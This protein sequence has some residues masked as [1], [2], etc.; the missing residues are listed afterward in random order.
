M[1]REAFFKDARRIMERLLGDPALFPDDA[2]ARPC[3]KIYT[4]RSCDV[5]TLFGPITL[6][7]RYYYH[8]KACTG[9]Y[10]LDEALDLVRGHTPALARL[11]CRASAQSASYEDAAA[12]LFHY[13]GTSLIGR[14]F[15]RL[16]ADI[17]PQLRQAQ[18]SLPA[19]PKPAPQQIQPTILYAACDGTGVPLRRDELKDI[20]GKQPDGSART[21][22]AK[23]GC[24]FTQTTTDEEGHPIRDPDS[25]TYVA[26]FE[27]CRAH[28]ILLRAEALRRGH[29]HIPTTVF[30]GDG[31]PWIWENARLNLPDAIQILDF[32]HVSEHLGTLAKSLLG[33]GP[34]ATQRQHDWCELIKKTDAQP[35]IAQAEKELDE[36]QASLTP[37]RI[38]ETQR[39]I[40]YLKTNRDRT[41]YGT[42][43][44]KGYFIGSGVVEAGCKTIVGKRLKQSGL[45]WSHRGGDDLLTLRCMT[46]GPSFESIWQ[47]RLPILAAIRSKPPRWTA[48]H[49]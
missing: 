46:L 42:Y 13:A 47:A 5:H 25:T 44:A 45:F 27:D 35:I 30:L 10:P 31:A 23:L 48:E 20:A 14:N 34:E 41:H 9:R 3:E 12:D 6:R 37:E 15:G 40:N 32:Y 29:A 7:R 8:T 26:T 33:A 24:I 4:S 22:E 49:N 43:Q 28:G 1:L 2:P 36:T 38:A 19:A 17:V 18:A 16:V 21:R 39:E 11:I